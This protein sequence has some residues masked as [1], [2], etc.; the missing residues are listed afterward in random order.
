MGYYGNRYSTRRN[1]I[2]RFLYARYKFY[3]HKLQKKCDDCLQTFL[4]R[5][6]LRYSNGCLIVARHNEIRDEI[7]QLSRQALYRACI[8][9]KPLIHQG[10]SRLKGCVCHGG[11]IPES[12]DAVLIRSLW[13]SRTEATIDI[14]F[15]DTEE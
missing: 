14:R 9:G 11:E 5:H 13:E 6:A 10:H 12:R 1:G 2:L 4:V 8:H 3:P 7:I 15:G